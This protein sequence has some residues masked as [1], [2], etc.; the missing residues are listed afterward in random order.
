MVLDGAVVV[1]GGAVDARS[2]V[3]VVLDLTAVILGWAVVGPGRDPV[4]VVRP[5]CSVDVFFGASHDGG[6]TNVQFPV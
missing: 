1:L 2:G 4:G 3:E 6:V 5:V